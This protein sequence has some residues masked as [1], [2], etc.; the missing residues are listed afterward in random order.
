MKLVS[1]HI[2][3]TAGTSFGK[4]LKEFFGNTFSRD[5]DDRAISKPEYER[6]KLALLSSIEIASKGLGKVNCV[7]GHF[8]PVKYLL[9]STNENVT[10]VTWMREPVE[11]MISHYN[12]WQRAYNS[13]TAAPHH[14]QVM[15]EKWT[16]EEFCLSPKFRNIYGQYLWAFP[17]EYF[18]FI[19][20]TEHYEEDLTYFGENYLGRTLKSEQ[21]N[22]ADTKTSPSSIDSALRKRIESYHE[23]DIALYRRALELRL[24]R[25]S[26]GRSIGRQ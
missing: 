9:L 12:F 14:K 11:R 21:L 25:R 6:N 18:G 13:E 8:L 1:V 15:E 22:T 3:K 4:S 10:F 5:Y 2:P 20:I 7:H 16:L 24:T 19:G 23:E 17:L 26:G